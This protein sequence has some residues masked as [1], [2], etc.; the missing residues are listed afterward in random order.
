MNLSIDFQPRIRNLCGLI[1]ALV[2][3]SVG[4]V[5]CGAAPEGDPSNEPAAKNVGGDRTHEDADGGA[6]NANAPSQGWIAAEP[7]ASPS[8][9]NA[10]GHPSHPP[11][12]Q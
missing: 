12:Q 9:G 7:T 2:A 4:S 8:G 1:A 3:L 6:T 11:L 5:A 10:G